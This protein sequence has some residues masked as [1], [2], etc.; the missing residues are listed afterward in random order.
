MAKIFT[1]SNK[2]QD[3]AKSSSLE[4]DGTTLVVDEKNDRVGIGTKTPISELSV[5]G[6]ISITSE[7]G[8]TP[9][10]PVDGNGLLYTKSDGKVYWRSNDVS[11]TDMTADTQLTTEAVQDI[12]GAMFTSNTETGISANSSYSP[13]DWILH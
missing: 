13:I 1:G 6:I 5:A 2:G 7:Q 12:V 3:K 9:S 11:E 10:Q 4:V 8:S